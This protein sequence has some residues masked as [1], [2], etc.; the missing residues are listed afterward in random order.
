MR[1]VAEDVFFTTQITQITQ[2]RQ[3][4]QITQITRILMRQVAKQ[5][6]HAFLTHSSQ[7]NIETQSSCFVKFLA[8]NSQKNAERVR[9]II[10][11]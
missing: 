3:I 7:R 5:K 11:T 6:E 8:Q 9:V 1:Q 4:R 2:I 10:R